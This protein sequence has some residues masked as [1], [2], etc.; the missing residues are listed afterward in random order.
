MKWMVLRLHAPLG[1]FG[2]EMVD[3]RGVISDAPGASML[4]GLLGNALG[5]T[6][7]MDGRLQRLQ[8]RLVFG[9]AWEHERAENRI[10]D[11]QTAAIGHGDRAWTSANEP[12]GRGGSP[13][14][15][16]GAHQR[17]RDYHSDMRVVVV[18]RL[19]DEDERPTLDDLEEALERPARGL[20][21]GRKSCIPSRPLFD[22][23]TDAALARSALHAVLGHRA[24]ESRGFWPPDEG[25]PGTRT[26][27]VSDL[28]DWR[29]GLHGGTRAL[30][31][32]MVAPRSEAT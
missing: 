14:K 21:I 10:T 9:A 8:E 23:W 26:M 30:E 31:E 2:R 7:S 11:Y 25:G 12:M 32:G 5:W 15:Y 27:H 20:Y 4:T 3:A 24:C 22:G 16:R 6:R 19:D 29:S 17:W 28:R 1:A 13:G 18:L